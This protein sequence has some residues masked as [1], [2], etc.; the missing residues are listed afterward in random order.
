M[1]TPFGFMSGSGAIAASFVLAAVFATT[2]AA[3][4]VL[5]SP[6]PLNA[7][8]KGAPLGGISSHAATGKDCGACHTS[9]WSSATMADRC[10]ACHRDVDS[11]IQSRSGL[12]GRFVGAL[13]SPACRGCHVDHRG[14][15]ASLTVTD[16]T[17]FP[18]DLTG[19]SLQG[20]RHTA[21]GARIT[22]AECHPNGLASFD[23]ATCAECHSQ[24]D[25]AFMTQHESRFGTNC[26]ACHH[27]FF[28]DGS[29]FD[30]NMLPFKLLG[31]HSGL[32]CGK[33][34]PSTSSI[35]ALQNTP[36]SCYACHAKN[37]AHKGQFGQSCEQC[38]TPSGWQNATFDHTVFPIDHGSQEQRA[39]CAT[40]H[41]NG[42]K[43]YSC[44]GCHR[45]T[46]TN[47]VAEHEGRSLSALT[48][49]IGCHPGGRA[50]D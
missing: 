4:P 5:F 44:F 19:Y 13:K 39:K 29:D 25:S 50:G 27:G 35:Q 8:P 22:C 17:T 2:L 7:V 12:H 37:D 14:R 20:H 48:N 9:P 34:H 36:T 10:L 28:K 6:G 33:C 49:C 11:Q 15:T 24:L 47:V 45:H 21:K 46:P 3:G 38:H 41:P 23:Q 42:V 31:K 30:H 43:T 32:A 40:C 16:P 18:H 1:R 26:L